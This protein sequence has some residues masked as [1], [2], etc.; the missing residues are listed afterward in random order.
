MPHIIN[1]NIIS[2]IFSS[3]FIQ[4]ARSLLNQ[5]IFSFRLLFSF[6][7]GNLL[8]DSWIGINP[9]MDVDEGTGV[10]NLLPMTRPLTELMSGCW[11]IFASQ[12]FS[13]KLSVL[14]TL[15]SCG[16]SVFPKICSS[17]PF[18]FGILSSSSNSFIIGITSAEVGYLRSV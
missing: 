7:P 1:T 4:T 10:M 2:I 18:I 14:A 15:K 9:L 11:G 12:V 8:V 5:G 16:I 17:A 13:Y 3:F 6:R